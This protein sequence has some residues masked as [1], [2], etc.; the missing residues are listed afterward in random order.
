MV[1]MAS[2][3]PEGHFCPR[4]SSTNF[5]KFSQFIFSSKSCCV[6]EFYILPSTSHCPAHQ[7]KLNETC[8]MY[9]EECIDRDNIELLMFDRNKI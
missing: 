7:L 2:N 4:V 8:G 6:E 1:G 9:I 3:E 5:P